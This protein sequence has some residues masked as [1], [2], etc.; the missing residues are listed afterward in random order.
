MSSVFI[1]VGQCGNQ[2]GFQF[3]KLLRDEISLHNNTVFNRDT[4]RA[5]CILVDSEPKVTDKPFQKASHP[6]FNILSPS[7]VVK[8]SNGRGNNWAMGYSDK[9]EKELPLSSTVMELL[10]REIEQCDYYKGCVLLHSLAGGTGSGLGSKLIEMI[11]DQYPI[12]FITAASI[13]P[14][15]SGDTPLQDYNSCLALSYLQNFADSIIYFENDEVMRQVEHFNK[16]G[17]NISTHNINECVAFNL[18][19]ILFPSRNQD[20]DFTGIY[21]DLVPC[22]RYKFIETKT[23]PFII[24]KQPTL[25][26]DTPWN[27]LIDSGI[28]NFVRQNEDITHLTISGKAILRGDDVIPSV[29][30]QIKQTYSKISS[31][32]RSVPW[33]DKSYLKI[34]LNST[35]AMSSSYKIDR[36]ITLAANRTSVVY[37]IKKLLTSA[38][39]KFRAGAYM[40]WYHKYNCEEQEFTQAFESLDQLVSDYQNSL[41]IKD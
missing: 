38:K 25:P 15:D 19:N 33:V 18:L 31:L 23:F 24:D 27:N 40:H 13:F 22:D 26:R 32:F 6:L 41:K 21:Q 4:E 12:C 29:D 16:R 10:R 34:S 2:V 14:S 28:K 9:P 35:K 8:S 37:P 39:A 11:R 30:R 17:S 20:I 3:W 7:L 5:R 1:Q 36:I